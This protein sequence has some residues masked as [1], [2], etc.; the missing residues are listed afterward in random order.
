MEESGLVT[1]RIVGEGA[2]LGLTFCVDQKQGENAKFTSGTVD[3][4]ID[5]M[6]FDFDT[7]TLS[8][9]ILVPMITTLYK[10]NIIHG[11]ERAV[12]KNLGVVVNGIGE[13]LSSAML[14]AEP[15]FNKQ[16]ET[17]RRSAKENEF[18][19]TYQERHQYLQQ[20]PGQMM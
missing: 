2:H 20:Q 8:H 16:L 6:D 12:E 17:M 13:Q 18:G 4:E 14:D 3:F 11:I 1:M 7:S 5:Q 10:R 19:R 9:N 15:R